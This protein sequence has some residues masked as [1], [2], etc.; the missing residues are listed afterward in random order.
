LL[1]LK[2]IGAPPIF[3]FEIAI[4]QAQATDRIH[5]STSRVSAMNHPASL[6]AAQ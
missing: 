3:A 5:L 6:L 4:A 1:V 2:R